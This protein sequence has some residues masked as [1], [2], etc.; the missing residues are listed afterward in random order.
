MT[1]SGTQLTALHETGHA[2]VAYAVGLPF[3]FAELTPDW[4]PDLRGVVRVAY[5]PHH[6]WP[7]AAYSLGGY[8]AEAIANPS[9]YSS[10]PVL[11][12]EAQ[13][14]DEGDDVRKALE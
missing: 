13:E 1:T 8:V 14:F 9:D 4:R 7:M 12:L 5:G 10:D 3:Q 2:L 11:L 6:P